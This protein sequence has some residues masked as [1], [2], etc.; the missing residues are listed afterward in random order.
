MLEANLAARKAR[1][2]RVFAGSKTVSRTISSASKA[3]DGAKKLSKRVTNIPA[4]AKLFRSYSVAIVAILVVGA[5]SPDN[6]YSYNS[7]YTP[8]L[9]GME[10]AYYGDSLLIATEDGYMPKINP[11][12][13]L[14]DRSTI[15]GRIVHEV[16]SGD[17]ISTIAEEYGLKTNTVLWENNLS[18]T[19]TLRIGDKLIIPPVD[20]V[21]HTVE[22]GQDIKKIASAYGIKEENII[23]QNRL[24]EGATL[25][26]GEA[27]FIPGAKPLP[28]ATGRDSSV[29]ISTA[30]RVA[31][32]SNVGST[33]LVAGSDIGSDNTN[34][35]AAGKS[36]IFPTRGKITQYYHP[37][38]YAY[39]I[40]DTSKP[41]I[42]AAMGGTVVK[43]SS[44]TWGGGYGNHIIID[45]GNGLKTLYAH[46]E[47][48]SVSVGDVVTQGQ[49]IGKMGKTGNVRGRTGIHLH[50]EV[51][52][53]GVKKSPANYF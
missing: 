42:W 46:M 28:A 8:S 2:K 35:P 44:G 51:I 32:K 5:I 38:H 33:K 15:N 47:Y 52:Q 17:T 11:Q 27:L 14:A 22:K 29:R 4:S 6:A 20:G 1:H 40:A 30:S 48:L 7:Y 10:E 19:S 49:V 53:N 34:S 23:K 25:S 16:V 24:A 12:T 36:M 37:G 21:T 18:A 43:A 45:H 26:T 3:V 39:D 41:P 31:S 13:E 9:D 50:F